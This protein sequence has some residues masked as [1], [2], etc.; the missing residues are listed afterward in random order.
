MQYNGVAAAPRNT[1]KPLTT[2]NFLLT[3]S[4]LTFV[5]KQFGRTQMLD[6]LCRVSFWHSSA[7][8]AA[9]PPLTF[10]DFRNLRFKREVPVKVKEDQEEVKMRQTDYSDVPVEW[11]SVKVI[12]KPM[13]NS[14][15]KVCQEVHQHVQEAKQITEE[16]KQ[17][18]AHIKQQFQALTQVRAEINQL[19]TIIFDKDIPLFQQHSLIGSDFLQHLGVKLVE[20]RQ[21][22]CK[23]GGDV[24][25]LSEI[26]RAQVIKHACT[27]RQVSSLSVDNIMTLAHAMRDKELL[28]TVHVGELKVKTHLIP[29]KE[30]KKDD[31]DGDDKD[32]VPI[33][34]PEDEIEAV[35]Q[36]IAKMKFESYGDVWDD[37]EEHKEEALLG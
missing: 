20:S 14:F 1:A 30:R 3:T 13:M 27:R 35:Q 15:F 5:D 33:D 10:G 4:F 26:H 7:V 2:D 28:N 11:N 25:S 36:T 34:N 23:S 29:I 22:V 17:H 37:E 18:K 24:S 6:W 31:N 12:D 8:Q 32:A 16:W 21:K 19:E 9:H